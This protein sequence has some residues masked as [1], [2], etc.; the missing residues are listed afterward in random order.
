MGAIKECLKCFENIEAGLV[1][2]NVKWG[3]RFGEDFLYVDDLWAGP[4]RGHVQMV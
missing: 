1:N 4:Q 2:L 3:G